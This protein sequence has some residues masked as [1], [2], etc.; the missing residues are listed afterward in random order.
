LWNL[1]TK[2]EEYD[3]RK[4]EDQYNRFPY[5][6]SNQRNVLEPK[7]SAFLNKN[8][9]NIK[10]PNG[11]KFGVCLTHD[12]DFVYQ[13]N[14]MMAYRG[15]NALRTCQFGKSL[16]VLMSRI[17]GS[18]NPNWNF[19]DIMDLEATY[20]AKSSFY[21]LALDK[22][23]MDY[24]FK[25]NVLGKEIRNIISNGWDVGLHGGHEAFNNLNQ[26]KI[27][28]ERLENVVEKQII[29]YR[30]HYFRFETPDTWECLKEAGFKYDTTFGYADCVGF[31]NGLCH[32]FKPFNL[33]TNRHIDI[34]EIPV[35]IMDT[36]LFNYMRLNLEQAWE[37]TKRLIDTVEKYGGIIT[38][39]WHIQNMLDDK[40]TYYRQLLQYC[41]EKDAWMTSAD[42]IWKEVTKNEIYICCH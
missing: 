30:N 14:L 22:S 32:P 29:G 13:S 25:I 26:M 23:N 16:K 9:L 38:F 4:L 12:V 7:V 8:G 5:Y 42:E 40:L 28:K 41:L 20:N 31:R 34:I 6:Y 27:E 2:K 21:F 3:L 11:K 39:N 10:Y 35:I 17:N 1:Y 19:K 24:T 15:Y 33:Y 37:L 36:T 18:L